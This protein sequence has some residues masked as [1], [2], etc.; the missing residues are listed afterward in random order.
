[1][2]L[3]L[4]RGDYLKSRGY[5]RRRRRHIRR[6]K[7]PR[8]AWQGTVV[9]RPLSADAS[10]TARGFVR[11][12]LVPFA[13]I[14]VVVVEV[15]LFKILEPRA[16]VTVVQEC[17]NLGLIGCRVRKSRDVVAMGGSSGRIFSGSVV[18]SQRG[19]LV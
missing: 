14:G 17:W 7:K 2:L 3:L 16:V 19:G 12:L 5:G 13:S 8:G 4:V 9:A 1:M 11:R 6:R 18:L 10:T 15:G